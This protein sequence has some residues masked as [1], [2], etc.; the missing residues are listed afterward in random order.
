MLCD[1]RDAALLP[2]RIEEHRV[3]RPIVV[4]ELGVERQER[5]LHLL[6]R[7]IEQVDVVEAAL[8]AHRRG[9]MDVEA[10]LILG[11][12][13]AV[14]YTCATIVVGVVSF[15]GSATMLVTGAAP[16]GANVT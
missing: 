4:P 6:A 5:I 16:G 10:Q 1:Q 14:G 7:I 8:H 13:S 11:N 3:A 2:A 12:H 15:A 9:E